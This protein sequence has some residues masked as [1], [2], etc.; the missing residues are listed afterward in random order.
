[1]MAAISTLDPAEVG[2]DCIAPFYDQFTADYAY[3]AWFAAIEERALELG[4]SGRRAL[5]L[6]CGTGKS[7]LPRRGRGY[8]A[9]GCAAS[10]GMLERARRKWPELADA[11]SVADMR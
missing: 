3:D 1:M 10:A 6:A 4:L 7:P 5:D 8:A 9:R 11:F 2:Y